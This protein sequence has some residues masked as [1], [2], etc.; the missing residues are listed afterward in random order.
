MPAPEQV[1]GAG[2]FVHSPMKYM[3]HLRSL[4]VILCVF[5]FSSCTDLGSEFQQ[6]APPPGTPVSFSRDIQPIFTRYGCNSCH[7][8]S[9]GLVVATV[10]EI[11]KGGNHGPAVVPGDPAVSLMIQKLSPTPPFG[12]R[13]PQGGAY[14]PDATIQIIRDWID[15]GASDN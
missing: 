9:G 4:F 2:S 7:G 11:L 5:L 6:M 1:F 13:M 15:Q 8:G 3:I 12:D 10:A 14:L